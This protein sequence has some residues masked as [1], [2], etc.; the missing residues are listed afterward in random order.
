MIQRVLVVAGS[1]VAAFVLVWLLFVALPRRYGAS[2]TRASAATPPSGPTVPGRKIKARLLYVGD[3]GTRLIGVE[4]DVPFG[5]STAEQARRIIEAQIAPP[6][7]PLVSAV[8][9][10]TTLRALFVTEGGEAFLDFSRELV[11]GHSGGSTN[12]AL[13]VYTLV[14]VLT[15]NLPAVT[16]VQVLIDG[17]PA[18]TLA[19]HI[20]LRRPLE[21]NLAWVQ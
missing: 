9:A 20:D 15:M 3:D 1:G 11:S 12:E 5:E 14:D 13:T 17:K 6:A 8:P 4:Q 18:E 19:G 10:G 21:K 2:S 7:E 16:A